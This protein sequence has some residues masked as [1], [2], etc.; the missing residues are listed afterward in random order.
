MGLLSDHS[1][2]PT[3]L[4][5]FCGS[6]RWEQCLYVFMEVVGVLNL[7]Y[8]WYLQDDGLILAVV[9]LLWSTGVTSPFWSCRGILTPTAGVYS[10]VICPSRKV[11]IHGTSSF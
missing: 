9:W 11:A 7:A 2:L 5:V 1:A 8:S 6:G 3:L 10:L 4:K